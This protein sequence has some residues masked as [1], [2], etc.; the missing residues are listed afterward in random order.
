MSK[1]GLEKAL[2]HSSA[3]GSK[4][5]KKH[6][7]GV[8]LADFWS[9]ADGTGVREDAFIT[10]FALIIM[11]SSGKEEPSPYFW[12]NFLNFSRYWE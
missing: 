2:Q 5:P 1:A 6:R 4:V 9:K 10:W 12:R 3:A 8:R 7:I 11:M